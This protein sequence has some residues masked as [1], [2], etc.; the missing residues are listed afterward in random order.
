MIAQ[1]YLTQLESNDIW[2]S[3]HHGPATSE[4]AVRNNERKSGTYTHL[5]TNERHGIYLYFTGPV[6]FKP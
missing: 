6:S 1:R 3:C 4:T 5:N 2:Q